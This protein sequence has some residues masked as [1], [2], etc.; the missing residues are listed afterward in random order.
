M[1]LL[2]SLRGMIR[3]ATTHRQVPRRLPGRRPRHRRLGVEVLEDR[4]LPSTYTVLNLADS[5]PGSLRQAVLDANAHP[6]PDTIR[7]AHG[8]HGIITLTS[9]EL[10]ITHSLDIEGPGAH[11][12]T[13]SGNHASRVF[14]ISSGGRG[15]GGGARGGSPRARDA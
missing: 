6:G 15:R 12:L 8:L 4:T 10:A 1:F 2:N 14:D 5:G 9:G 11:Q 3:Q 13:V 7:F